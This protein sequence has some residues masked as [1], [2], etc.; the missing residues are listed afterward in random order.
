MLTAENLSA[1]K[2]QFKKDAN[3]GTRQRTRSIVARHSRSNVLTSPQRHCLSIKNADEGV[4]QG[5]RAALN[6]QFE[7][8]IGFF[9]GRFLHVISSIK[10]DVWRA[11]SRQGVG[12]GHKQC[13]SAAFGVIDALQA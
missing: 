7:R 4:K 6:Q 8:E 1:S 3:R 10:S 13:K 11:G 5:P 9:P 12:R 2:G